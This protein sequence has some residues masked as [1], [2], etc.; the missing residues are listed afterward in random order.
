MSKLSD[1]NI[2]WGKLFCTIYLHRCHEK[3]ECTIPGNFNSFFGSDPCGGVSKYLDITY[4][5]IGNQQASDG[6]SSGMTELH[7]TSKF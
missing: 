5:C 2:Q 6:M 1:M 4:N 3:N 7:V